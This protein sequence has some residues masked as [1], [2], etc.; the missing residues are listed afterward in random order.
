[1]E[2]M[3]AL[4]L[5]NPQVCLAGK[6]SSSLSSLSALLHVDC[7]DSEVRRL[8]GGTLAA[9]LTQRGLDCLQEI[10]GK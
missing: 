3:I 8:G 9:T 1:M 7:S 6:M 10:S 4:P 5:T 2:N